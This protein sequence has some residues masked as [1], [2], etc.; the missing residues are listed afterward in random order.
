MSQASAQN[1]L[2]LGFA[3]GLL[4]GRV[5]VAPILIKI[6]PE[7]VTL[8]ASI[9]MA[10]T[11]FAMLQ[12]NDP[13]LAGIAV[14][15]AGVAMAPVFPTTLAMVGDAYPRMTSTA[16]GIVITSGWI[17]LVI[18]SPV[19]GALA[20]QDPTGLRTALLV[21]PVLSCAMVVVNLALR[22]AL[23]RERQAS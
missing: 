4:V 8:V 12:T 23:A 14:F 19:I 13:T 10:V 7:V 21:L 6:K 20:G 5:A 3:L 2:S 9:L 1:I 22:P 16:M 18:S 15:C 11:T 17:G